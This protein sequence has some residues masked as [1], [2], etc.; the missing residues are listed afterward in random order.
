M[1]VA[2]QIKKLVQEGKL[3]KGLKMLNDWAAAN[4]DSLHNTTILLLSRFNQLKRNSSMGIISSSDA[5]RSR[6]QLSYALLSTLE[7]LPENVF[8][9]VF[10]G[11]P[12]M[13]VEAQ[14]Q[15]TNAPKKLFISYARE[16]R[17][18]VDKLEKHLTALIRRRKISS[19]TDSDLRPG[20]S[21]DESILQELG[22]ADIVLL[23]I[24]ADFLASNYIYE[25]EVPKAME[26]FAS[27]RIKVIPVILSPSDWSNEPYAQF[28]ALPDNAKPIVQWENEDEALLSVVKGI[29]RLLE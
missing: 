25:K 15:P 9:P 7:D 21:W 26:R 13:P 29:A 10:T 28:N 17:A 14:P 23:L 1:T 3:E 18:W 2:D 20:D 5:E 12:A 11:E 27:D 8:V 19:W 22:Q 6:N 16:D 4:D 24:S